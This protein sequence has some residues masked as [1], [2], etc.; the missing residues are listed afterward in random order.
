MCKGTTSFF[1]INEI[2]LGTTKEQAVANY[3][4]W[5]IELPIAHFESA[6]G[7]KKP[8]QLNVK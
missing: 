8:E 5:K 3:G 1:G 7:I 6:A 4:Q 2:G